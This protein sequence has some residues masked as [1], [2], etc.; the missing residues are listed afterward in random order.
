MRFAGADVG[1]RRPIAIEHLAGPPAGQP[2]QVGLAATLGEPGVG[3]GVAK[4]VRVQPWQ[5]GLLSAAAQELLDSPGGQA[6][7][8]AEPEPGEIGV[9]VPGADAKVAVQGYGGLAAIGQGTLTTTLA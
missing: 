7:S 8:L 4:L 3:K 6:A 9:L 2:H 5:A 1:G